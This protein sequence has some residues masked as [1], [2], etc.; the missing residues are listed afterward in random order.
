MRCAWLAACG[1]LAATLLP[2]LPAHAEYRAYELEVVDLYDCRINKRETC[3]SGRLS[4]GLDP[5]QYQATHG[6]PYH[7]GVLLLATWMCY[8]D[9][10]FY[11]PV[12]PRPAAKQP[13]FNVGDDVTIGLE[14]HITEGWRGKVEVA[15]YQHSVR[16][17]VYGVR[18]PDRRGVYARYYEKDLRKAGGEGAPAAAG[19][20]ASTAQPAAGPT[21]ATTT[22]PTPAAGPA[23][24]VTPPP[25][26]TAPAAPA[27]APAAA[28]A[29]QGAPPQ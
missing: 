5:Q 2:A 23:A 28:G 8:G 14:K 15:Y 24:A 7:V 6:G 19:A 22:V 16:S 11:K 17:N 10:S 13:R 4:T 25:A 18:F 20:G 27:A 9:T 29:P 3:R 12:C 26:A 21:T 1:L